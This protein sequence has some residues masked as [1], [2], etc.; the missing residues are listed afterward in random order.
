MK[1]LWL[2]PG[3]TSHESCIDEVTESE[4]AIRHL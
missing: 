3:D 2:L 4:F 1:V